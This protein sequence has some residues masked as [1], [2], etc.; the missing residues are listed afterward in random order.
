MGR[1][2]VIIAALILSFS[3][4][5]GQ[6]STTT[7][8]FHS[9]LEA[10]RKNDTTLL[11]RFATQQ[12][13]PHPLQ[14]YLDFHTLRIALPALE[15]QAILDYGNTY[16]DSPLPRDLRDIAIAQYGQAQQW[17]A[18]LAISPT[19][20]RR[21]ELRCFYYQAKWQRGE[22]SA[23]TEAASLWQSGTSRP[24]SCDPL[25]KA[26]IDAQI[27]SKEDIWKRQQLA[28][29]AG[30]HGLMRYLGGQLKGTRYES[31]SAQLQ[32]LYHQPATIAT[33]TKATREQTVLIHAALHRWAAA[34]TVAAWRWYTEPTEKPG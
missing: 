7:V 10:A 3:V 13:S 33:Q 34:D 15:P 11:E 9:A 12:S 28:F 1:S 2:V 16:D 19:A 24:D 32:T 20:P 17:D 26:A 8:S 30:N 5:T 14:A 18:L 25:F 23:L 6:A 29:L 22:E 21:T 4:V 27:I 31:A